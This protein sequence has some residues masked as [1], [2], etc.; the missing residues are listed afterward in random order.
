MAELHDLED[1]V[2][3]RRLLARRAVGGD[4][5]GRELRHGGLA[6]RHRVGREVYVVC[7]LLATLCVV[8][9]T[10]PGCTEEGRGGLKV[11]QL[12]QQGSEGLVGVRVDKVLVV[13]DVGPVDGPDERLGVFNTEPLAVMSVRAR[14]GMGVR[15]QIPS[16]I[17]QSLAARLGWLLPF[18]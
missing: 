16:K 17:E 12:G 10:G 7:C 4:V 5:E 8:Q 15:P 6:G 2:L 14:R 18:S 1:V 13:L 11:E 3:K 9:Q